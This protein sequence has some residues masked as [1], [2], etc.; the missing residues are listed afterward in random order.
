MKTTKVMVSEKKIEKYDGD[1]LVFCLAEA[2]EGPI[3]CNPFIREPV[4]RAQEYGDFSGKLN[5]TLVFYPDQVLAEE[6]LSA[7]RV[8][9]I[10]IGKP[11][12]NDATD[13]K[14][15]VDLGAMDDDLRESFRQ[16]GGTI[17]KTCAEVKAK[18]IMIVLPEVVDKDLVDCAECITEGVLLGDYRFLKYKTKKREDNGDELKYTGL[19]EV[20]CF[21]ASGALPVVRKAVKQGVVAAQAT[22]AAR[23]MANEPGNGWKAS[24]F[25]AYA[26]E[27]SQRYGMTYTFFDKAKLQEMKMGGILAVNQGSKE[28]PG[29][30]ILE[31]RPKKKA[32]TI[33]LVGKGITFDSGG[34]CV[35]PAAGMEDMKY[36]MCGG[37]AVLATMQAV[38][39]EKPGVGVIAIIPTT[40][41]L[42]GSNAVK[43][44]DIIRHYD[45]TTS[46]II[47]TDAEGRMILADALAYG[48]ETYQPDCVVDVATLTGAVIM[49]LGHHCSGVMSNH[50]ALVRHL[51]AAGQLAG[52]PLWRLPLGKPYR[53]QIESKVADIKNTGG[54]S[55]GTITAGAYLEHFVGDTPWAHLDIAGTAWDFTD[56]SYIPKGPSGIGVRTFLT[57]I[58]HWRKGQLDI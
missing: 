41:N 25:A 53:K 33:L 8:L 56:K 15:P 18:K 24:D 26:E 50:D 9:I 44:G 36:D 58:R 14:H 46:E 27:L 19:S 38:G 39:Q 21:S 23:D 49:G 52:E 57:L 54:K 17:A 51:E 32:Q 22:C 29:L 10:G 37:A 20:R 30:V 3:A 13:P 34:I 42:S 55:A 6:G 28:A 40:D 35:K 11:A 7:K 31:Y 4:S 43:P 2:K 45:G 12:A 47:N 1:L 48:I 5:E 16:V